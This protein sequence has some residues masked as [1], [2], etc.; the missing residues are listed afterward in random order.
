[1]TP[2]RDLIGTGRHPVV[3]VDDASGKVPAIVDMAAALAPFA[4]GP[5]PHY[6]GVR[7]VIEES[8][9]AAF[10]Y[11]RDL[12][13]GTAPFSAGG[14]DLDA[15]DLLEASFSMV[16]AVPATLTAAQRAPHFDS[17]DANYIAV[18]HYLTNTP[19]TAFYRQRS[20]GIEA[21]T[22]ETYDRFVTTV[23]AEGAGDGY[24]VTD[25][26]R[27]ERIGSV[28]GKTDRLVIYQGRLLHSGIIPAGAV[29]S[30]DPRVGRLT[31]NMFVRGR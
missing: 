21:V 25:D 24:I 7:R 8:D 23:R 29:L 3:I 13:E 17:T 22:P 4:K 26:E 2:R 19:G 27:F 16:T 10:G 28:E 12:L 9:P 11:V 14:F 18:L 15:F 5:N 6:P 30:A 31:T 1:M 20:T